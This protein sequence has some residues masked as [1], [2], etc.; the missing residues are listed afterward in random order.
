M[1]LCFLCQLFRFQQP[2]VSLEA[3]GFQKVFGNR[4]P[5]CVYCFMPVN[6]KCPDDLAADLVESPRFVEILRGFKG[7]SV[8]RVKWRT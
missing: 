1:N 3:T 7:V 2:E 5:F 4:S 8:E 6:E